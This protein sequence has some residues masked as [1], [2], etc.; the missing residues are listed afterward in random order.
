ML[1]I[2]FRR[3]TVCRRLLFDRLPIWMQVRL[4][5]GGRSLKTILMLPERQHQQTLSLVDGYLFRV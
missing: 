4:S 1:M 5:C 3:Y 2:A